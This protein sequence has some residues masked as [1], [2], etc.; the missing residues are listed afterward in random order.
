MVWA[1]KAV[2]GLANLGQR[3]GQGL[4]AL[5]QQ[6]QGLATALPA[7]QQQDISQQMAL[8]GLGRGREQSLLDLASKLYRSIQFTDANF[9]KCLEH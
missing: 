2:L 7:L 3:L 8:G 9:T 4:G 6:Y 5:G 1:Y